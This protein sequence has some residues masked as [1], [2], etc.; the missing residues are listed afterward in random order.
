MKQNY[1]FIF[2]LL[3]SIHANAAVTELNDSAKTQYYYDKAYQFGIYH[4]NYQ[5][6]M[7][8]ILM[9]NPHNAYFWQQ[10]GMP[11]LKANKPEL[12]MPCL[13][14]TVKYKSA[15]IDYRAF[16]KCIFAKDYKGAIVDFK[17]SI[18]LKG[19]SFIMDHSYEFYIALS[20][21]QLNNLPAADSML[22]ISMDF[23]KSHNS[24]PHYLELFY[25]GII[26]MER[27]NFNLAIQTFD[28][29]LKMYSQL[30]EAHFYKAQCLEI[31]G[32]N[33][34]APDRTAEVLALYQKGLEE[35][36]KGY[37][38]NE[39]NAIYMDYPYQIRRAIFEAYIRRLLKEKK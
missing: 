18:K 33:D 5:I 39:D 17:E 4:I 22:R 31:V 15:Y 36:K 34:G 10:K 2:L 7:D 21:L 11:L 8:S 19:H 25:M 12:G 9:L 35:Y 28:A 13:D 38:I 32:T 29:V 30:P 26:H 23:Y 6:Y 14:S 3:L 37:G 20:Y 27:E 24:D 1:L 16:M